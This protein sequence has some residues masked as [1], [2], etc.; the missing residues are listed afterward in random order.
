MSK[1]IKTYSYFVIP[2]CTVAIYLFSIPNEFYGKIINNN[3]MIGFLFLI[4]IDVD[5]NNL[6]VEYIQWK[7][8]LKLSYYLLPG[9]II[10]SGIWEIILLK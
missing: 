2:Y 8:S 4:S 1:C 6:Q 5:Y 3:K 10:F 9:L 7:K